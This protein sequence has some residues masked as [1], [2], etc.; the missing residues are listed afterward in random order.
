MLL[1]LKKIFYFLFPAN[2]IWARILLIYKEQLLLVKHRYH[3]NYVF[4]PWWWVKHWELPIDCLLR[5]LKE[6]IWLDLFDKKDEIKL[7]W[8]YNNTIENKNDYIFLFVYKIEDID[9]NLDNIKPKSFE[10]LEISWHDK[11]NLPN[12]ISPGAKRRI[13]EYI[14]LP[15]EIIMKKW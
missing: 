3:K 4:F 11:N 7:F 15:N 14:S 13:Q 6:E 1:F 9:D 2:T 12:N 10:I 8:I 5:E